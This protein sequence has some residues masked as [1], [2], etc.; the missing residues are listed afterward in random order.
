MAI[1]PNLKAAGCVDFYGGCDH[2]ILPPYDA[3]TYAAY[4][5]LRPDIAHGNPAGGADRTVLTSSL[6]TPTTALA[7]GRQY[8]LHPSMSALLPYWTASKLAVFINIGTLNRPTTKA[9]YNTVGYDIPGKL[10]SHNDQQAYFQ[11]GYIEPGPSGYFGRMGDIL[12][13]Q[14][15][16]AALTCVTVNRNAVLL[17]GVTTKSY[18]VAPSGPAQFSFAGF[19]GTYSLS[20]LLLPTMRAAQPHKLRNELANVFTRAETT[21]AVVVT[22][23]ASAPPITTVFPA[24]DIGAQLYAIAR[25]ITV[26]NETG[27]QRFLFHIN[28]D[29]YD[30]HSNLAGVGGATGGL[31]T[32]LA[33]AAAAMKAFYDFTVEFGIANKVV[34]FSASEFSR[35]LVSNSG[36]ADHGWG[37][38]GLALGGPVIGK[39]FYGTPP[40]Y[41]NNGADDIGEGRFVPS[42]GWEQ[43]Y[44]TLAKWLGIIDA[45]LPNVTEK[46]LNW[47][48]GQRTL[49][50]LP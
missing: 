30:D 19:G 9:Q 2:N 39:E 34:L 3:A 12:A 17:S 47:P 20:N 37:G 24:T 46:I 22:A 4:Y 31:A 49:G 41:A 40:A 35:T 11:S 42:T 8:A 13:A 33:Q 45:Q 36:G 44:A 28:Q 5:N 23:L 6:L 18:T 26:S 38:Y 1:H 16:Y 27:T 21:S 43:F 48:S 10:M 15:T 50:F 32:R 14:N 29:G 7:G 25:L